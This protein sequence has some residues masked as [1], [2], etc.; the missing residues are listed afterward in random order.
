VLR[1][2]LGDSHEEN[3]L[4]LHANRSGIERADHLEFDMGRR[5]V[6]GPERKPSVKP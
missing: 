3:D 5:S 1:R 2:P 6:S 4:V